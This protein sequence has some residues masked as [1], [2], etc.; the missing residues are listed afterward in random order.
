MKRKNSVADKIKCRSCKNIMECVEP[1]GDF[2]CYEQ[3]PCLS[4]SKQYYAAAL[5]VVEECKDADVSGMD[6]V[7]MIMLSK[8]IAKRFNAERD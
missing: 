3:Q 1:D 2:D 6:K 5:E 7:T 8:W 4:V